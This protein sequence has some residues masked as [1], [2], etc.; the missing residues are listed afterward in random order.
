MTRYDNVTFMVC[1]PRSRSAWLAEFLK[2][3]AHTM[4]DPLKQCESIDELGNKLDEI[5]FVRPHRP[6]FVADTAAALL[7]DE[8]SKRFPDAKYL[9]VERAMPEVIGSVARQRGFGVFGIQQ[10]LHLSE[11]RFWLAR[12][13]ARARHDL[14]LEVA[15]KEMDQRL[16][17]IWRFVGGDALLSPSYAEAMKRRNIQIPFEEQ[18]A[19]TNVRKVR[20][21]LSHID[22][23]AD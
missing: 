5:L 15:Y 7:F 22:L 18:A 3:V 16:R 11:S 23:D 19:N 20:R 9:F 17:N 10:A 2:P 21:L 13:V 6:V 1:L 4:H 14:M 8:I 12:N